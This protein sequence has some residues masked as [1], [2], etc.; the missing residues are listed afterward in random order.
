MLDNLSFVERRKVFSFIKHSF[1]SPFDSAALGDHA[2]HPSSLVVS[3]SIAK[4]VVVSTEVRSGQVIIFCALVNVLRA[5]DK[6]YGEPSRR[7]VCGRVHKCMGFYSAEFWSASRST[8]FIGTV[9]LLESL[10]PAKKP[11]KF[12]SETNG[13]CCNKPIAKWFTLYTIWQKK[14][15]TVFTWSCSLETRTN[16]RFVAL[17]CSPFVR[18]LLWSVNDPHRFAARNFQYRFSINMLSCVIGD[19][20]GLFF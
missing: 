15:R 6:R 18:T 13:K 12:G 9:E 17:V 5:C 2:S 11:A 1:W 3:V 19:Q 8:V 7:L 14:Q 16:H 10:P 4:N 20:L